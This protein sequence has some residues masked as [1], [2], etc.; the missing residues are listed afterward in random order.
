MFSYSGHATAICLWRSLGISLAGGL[1]ARQAVPM[2]YPSV[3]IVSSAAAALP[4]PSDRLENISLFTVRS[5]CKWWGTK[6]KRLYSWTGHRGVVAL[7]TLYRRW[8]GYHVLPVSDDTWGCPG[9]ELVREGPK[10][11]YFCHRGRGQFKSIVAW[12]AAR[13]SLLLLLLLL[14][15]RSCLR[16]KNH[17]PEVMW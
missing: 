14:L 8:C 3:R 17:R 5:N 1:R 4:W 16:V 6:R 11:L 15:L 9:L 12:A 2:L 10:N 7:V 13:L